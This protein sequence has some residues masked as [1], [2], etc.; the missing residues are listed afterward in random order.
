LNDQPPQLF[1]GTRIRYLVRLGPTRLRLL[2]SRHVD[3]RPGDPVR[4][5]IPPETIR[6]SHTPPQVSDDSAAI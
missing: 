3:L 1:L 2:A 4:L 5:V 6:W